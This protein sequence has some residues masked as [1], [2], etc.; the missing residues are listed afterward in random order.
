MGAITPNIIGAARQAC[1]ERRTWLL[2]SPVV[3]ASRAPLIEVAA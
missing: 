2:M 1:V 3:V